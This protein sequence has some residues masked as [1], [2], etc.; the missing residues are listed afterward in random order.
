MALRR[1]ETL[2]RVK[3]EA[4]TSKVVDISNKPYTI[5]SIV[6]AVRAVV[7]TGAA[8]GTYN[9]PWDR[10]I[11]SMTITVAGKT[12]VSYT[13]MRVAYAQ[14]LA[15]LDVLAPKRPNPPGNSA[16]DYARQFLYVFHFGVSPL[17]IRGQAGS[18]EGY[19]WDLTAGI[20]P[21]RT[22]AY[23]QF[24]WGA[25]NAGGSGWTTDAATEVEF[26]AFGVQPET[27]DPP[28]AYLP[29]AIPFWFH[30][31][32]S[33]SATVQPR[34]ASINVP[35][36]MF[37]RSVQLLTYRGAN[38]PR[39][40]EVLNSVVL[41]DDFRN[42]ELV[43]IASSDDWKVAESAEL[44]TQLYF[45]GNGWPPTMDPGGTALDNAEAIA[46][47]RHEGLIHLPLYLFAS[48]GNL[49][50]LYGFDLRGAHVGQLKIYYGVKTATNATLNVIYQKY[51]LNPEHPANAGL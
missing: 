48:K 28:D 22:N 43:T 34:G 10:L 37:L 3:Y 41:R 20:P 27:G 33:I 29:R 8:A 39:D 4:G 25:A 35:N 15:H 26:Y 47:T 50:D 49:G 5:T 38:N 51:D 21:N 6:A 11:S 16:V 46:Q 23:I 32:P 1:I 42:I 7:D 19:P 31:T 30:E 40:N 13:D 44:M 2:G 18:I 45:L 9:D 12:I 36:G 17:R 14:Q 24:T